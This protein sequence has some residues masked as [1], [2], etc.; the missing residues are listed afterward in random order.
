MKPRA[1]VAELMG[2]FALTLAVIVSINNPDFPVST[3]V[4]AGLT[5]GCLVYTIGPVSGCHINPAVTIGLLSI[6]R[7]EI[8]DAAAYILVQF[9]GAG[10]AMMVGNVFFP[11]PAEV[12]SGGDALTGFAEMFGAAVFVF[13]IAAVVIGRAPAV[14]SGLIIGS[15]LVVG[16]SLAAHRGN[17]VLNPA[18]ALAVGS[19]SHPYLWGP[20]TGA[21]VGATLCSGLA[22]PDD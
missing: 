14:T 3:P 8:S 17:G 19:F 6:G 1:L 7:V 13:G 22:E 20:V 15:S 16:I 12:M 2:T 21:I 9:G 5:L 10:L 4:I 18:V 11:M